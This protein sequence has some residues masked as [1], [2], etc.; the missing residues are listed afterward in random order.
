MVVMSFETYKKLLFESEVYFKLKEADLQ[1]TH[2]NQRFSHKEVFDS[3]KKT[4][5]EKAE[6]FLP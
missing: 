2:T 4:L 1:A 3:L 5:Q 6:A